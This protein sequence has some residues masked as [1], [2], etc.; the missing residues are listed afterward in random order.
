MGK[1]DKLEG[2]KLIHSW[3]SMDGLS[4]ACAYN[5]LYWVRF[6]CIELLSWSLPCGPTKPMLKPLKLI[7]EDHPKHLLSQRSRH[8]QLTIFGFRYIFQGGPLNL[9][10][11]TVFYRIEPTI[12]VCSRL[13][14][15]IRW[16]RLPPRF[17]LFLKPA[18]PKSMHNSQT[19]CHFAT[20]P[21][22]TFVKMCK[23]KGPGFWV[24]ITFYLS[25]SVLVFAWTNNYCSRWMSG[26]SGVEFWWLS[27]T[28]ACGEWVR[29]RQISHKKGIKATPI[30]LFEIK[31]TFVSSLSIAIMAFKTSL[32]ALIL[33]LPLVLGMN[34]SSARMLICWPWLQLRQ[35][36][37]DPRHVTS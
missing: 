34:L 15:H 8:G 21:K 11:S 31:A 29:W 1:N 36:K 7:D 24:L 33:A 2:F 13:G 10:F 6:I 5:V 37:Y 32:A 17:Q 12:W 22:C 19:Q 14:F 16:R 4:D 30:F 23:S 18:G 25:T 35:V 28:N 9:N 3:C 27:S 20:R 26:V